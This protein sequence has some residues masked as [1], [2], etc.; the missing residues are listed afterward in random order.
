MHRTMNRSLPAALL[1]ALVFPGA[2]QLYLGR[3]RRG[4]TIALTVASAVLLL[5][6]QLAGPVMTLVH[7]IEDGRLA[8]D[9]LLIL[10]RVHELGLADNA[11][12]MPAALVIVACWIG[13]TIDAFLLGSNKTP[14]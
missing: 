4:W 1:S 7:D 11:L 10:T 8:L 14:G 9:P 2:G 13:S 6:C 12:L 5:L 3:R